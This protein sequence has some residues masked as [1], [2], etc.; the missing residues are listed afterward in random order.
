MY[1]IYV[2]TLCR[3]EITATHINEFGK[4]LPDMFKTP[5]TE[6][7]IKSIEYEFHSIDYQLLFEI[8]NGLKNTIHKILQEIKEEP[9]HGNIQDN[10]VLTYL[11][12]TYSDTEDD[13]ELFKP[14]GIE[15]LQHLQAVC[16]YKLPLVSVFSCLVFF[17]QWID[18]GNY[19]FR[20][21]PLSLKHQMIP[22]DV[23]LLESIC[24]SKTVNKMKLLD[25]LDHF[26]EIL[27]TNEKNIIQKS[28][29]QANVSVVNYN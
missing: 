17:S 18:D 28:R 27:K 24:D 11:Q 6:N 2:F 23:K 16:L 8:V 15:N 4:V 7:Q 22:G 29:E 26:I 3:K 10:T 12:K 14:I 5:L 19:N 13:K 25:E 20:K 9:E 21:V 1:T